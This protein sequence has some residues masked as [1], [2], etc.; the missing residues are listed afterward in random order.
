MRFRKAR[1]SICA[2]SHHPMRAVESPNEAIAQG[3][4][5]PCEVPCDL[6]H[7]LDVAVARDELAAVA[8]RKEALPIGLWPCVA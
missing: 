5:R 2:Q 6:W 1:A 8:R 3:L 7:C 4:A